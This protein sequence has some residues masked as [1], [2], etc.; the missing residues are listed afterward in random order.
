MAIDFVYGGEV[1]TDSHKNYT[2]CSVICTTPPTT[3]NTICICTV[4]M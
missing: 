4:S 3:R 2:I 1:M